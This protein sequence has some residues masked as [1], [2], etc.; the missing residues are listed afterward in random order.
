M[1]KFFGVAPE[2][3]EQAAT[4]LLEGEILALPTETVYGL[5]AL[6][7]NERAVEK[8][9]A[10][11]RRPANDPL[12][13]HVADAVSLRS[14]CRPC[15]RTLALAKAF[16]PGPLTL[17]LPKDPCVPDLVTS[18]LSTVAVRSPSHPVFRRIL[19]LVGAPLAAPSANPFGKVSPTT[20]RHV[21]ESFGAN[22]PPVVD[23]GRT[24][25]GVEST[26]LD[27]SG[28]A[29]SILRPGPIPPDDVERIL[30]E[31][32]LLAVCREISSGQP[33]PSPGLLSAHYRTEA[34]LRLFPNLSALLD[35]AR[36]TPPPPGS[37]LITGKPPE[38]PQGLPANLVVLPLSDTGSPEEIARNLFAVLRRADA[39]S[40]PL[41]LA[42]LVEET[43]LGRAV[44]DR[45]RRAAR[46]G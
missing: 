9:F 17:V 41:I 3:L 19:Q 15:E 4:L 23:G 1:K 42:H 6:A 7:L 33:A 12:I 13:V 18:G 39:A 2:D 43:G 44:N 26:I 20:A 11:K 25:H 30:G 27:L 31:R 36:R 45:L 28:P 21:V 8:I 35:H 5:A 46:S 38:D 37:R 16:W 24:E 34:P 29:P 22:H 32:P 40:P 14:V 10:A